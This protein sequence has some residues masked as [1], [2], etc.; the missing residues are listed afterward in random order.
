MVRGRIE[1]WALAAAGLLAAAALGAPLLGV[2][3]WQPLVVGAAVALGLLYVVRRVLA[4]ESL[5]ERAA[6]SKR[7]ALVFLLLPFAF[8]L[9]LIPWSIGERAPDGD[10]PWFLLVTHSIAYDLDR[11]LANNYRDE[12]S[13]ASCRERSSRSPETPKGPTAPSTRGTASS[14]RPSWPRPTG[15]AAGPERWS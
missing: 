15:S 7:P 4:L 11:D 9:A 12:D 14:C 13:L 10:E 3:G 6:S 1:T 2:D 8:Y 5:L